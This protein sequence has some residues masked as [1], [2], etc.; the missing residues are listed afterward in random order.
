MI[1]PTADCG[2]QAAMAASAAPVAEG[3]VGAGAGATIGKLAGM[4]RAMKSG[5]GSAVLTIPNGLIVAALVI[6][7]AVGDVIDPGTGRII[8][9]VR[10]PDGRSF[11][12]ARTL[13]R[14]GAISFT[15]SGNTTLGIIATNALMAIM[16][17]IKAAK[18]AN[19]KIRQ[20]TRRSNSLIGMSVGM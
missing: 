13:L 11:A 1:R 5:V 12:D 17:V 4:T 19:A 7:N 9:G 6:V 20:S 16:P 18:K 15:G 8:A 3:S 14:R 2:Y 10:T